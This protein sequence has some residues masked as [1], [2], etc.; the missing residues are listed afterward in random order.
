[1]TL[2]WRAASPT[3]G[4]APLGRTGPPAPPDR[5]PYAPRARLLRY[6]APGPVLRTRAPGPAGLAAR[7]TA[8]PDPRPRLS[9]PS[10]L[11]R[12][13]RKIDVLVRAGSN[14]MVGPLVLL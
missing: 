3:P 6:R 5:T 7:R 8:P 10:R 11:T 13:A 9:D 1:M 4:L 12:P 2:S 14:D